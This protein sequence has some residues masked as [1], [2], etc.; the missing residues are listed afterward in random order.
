MDGIFGKFSLYDFMGIWGPGAISLFY[1]SFTLNDHI[2]SFLESCNIT[3]PSLSETPLLIL[4][5]TI[6][7]YII[8]MVLHELGHWFSGGMIAAKHLFDKIRDKRNCSGAFHDINHFFMSQ[9]EILVEAMLK[10]SKATTSMG[11]PDPVSKIGNQ[12]SP[13]TFSDIVTEI[14][15]RT[16]SDTLR[17]D[18]FH[19]VY[20]MARSVMLMSIIHLLACILVNCDPNADKLSPWIFY[21]DI[22]LFVMFFVRTSHYYSLWV[23][24]VCVQYLH[25][26]NETEQQIQD[27]AEICT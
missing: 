18:K 8:G 25:M 13:V 14:K 15:C 17:I 2:T 1:F 22:A 3:W 7:A 11:T 16:S 12:N 20:A 6:V 27:N 5:Y 24:T 10:K 9:D 19:A 4:L 21:A 26:H 23:E